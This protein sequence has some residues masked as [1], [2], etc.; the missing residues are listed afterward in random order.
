MMLRLADPP[1]DATPDLGWDDSPCPLCNRRDE[2]LVLEAPDASPGTARPLVFAVVR[3]RTCGLHYTNPRPDART[4]RRFY[5]TDYRPHRRPRKLREAGRPSVVA[6]W[7]G[8]A[9]PERDGTLP[10]Q[11]QGRLLD[12]G[13]GGGGYLKRM[14]DH[15]WEVT[16]LDNAVGAVRAV[17]E[18][19]GLRAL[20]GTLPH[21]RLPPASFDVVTMWHSLEHVHRPLATLREAW[22][23]LVP[24]GR[25]VVAC[26]NRASWAARAF[27][28]DWF[29]LDLPRH[30]THFDPATL[31]HMLTAAGF[32]VT[33]VRLIRHSDWLR[34]SAKLAATRG[35]PLWQRPLTRKPVAKLAAGLTFAAG[36]SDCMVAV[37]ERPG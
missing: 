3:C 30:L 9:C 24:G 8:R 25:L 7:T 13:C 2:E 34:S 26:P 22:Q 36:A 17:Q 16:G 37:A 19:L 11:G 10:W 32:A 15:G 29:A 35:G 31:T 4:I 28:P 21:P 20:A 14:A 23:V 6:R 1:A 12:F 18:E 5:P 33:D 27:G